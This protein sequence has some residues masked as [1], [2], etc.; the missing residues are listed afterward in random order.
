MVFA[1][2]NADPDSHWVPHKFNVLIW[3][4]TSQLPCCH[5]TYCSISCCHVRFHFVSVFSCFSTPTSFSAVALE[6][7]VTSVGYELFHLVW[8]WWAFSWKKCIWKLF[9]GAACKKKKKKKKSWTG[10]MMPRGNIL[11]ETQGQSRAGRRG[12]KG[13]QSYSPP[14]ARLCS[15]LDQGG[16]DFV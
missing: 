11:L 5:R 6:N 10:T 14:A 7:T 13:L 8:G 16:C 1:L 15:T 9:E 4:I 3:C 2:F 12:L